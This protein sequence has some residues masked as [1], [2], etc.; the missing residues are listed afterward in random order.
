M[1]T[2]TIVEDEFSSYGIDLGAVPAQPLSD[3]AA[4]EQEANEWARLWHENHI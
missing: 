1:G 3:Q 4:V 2:E